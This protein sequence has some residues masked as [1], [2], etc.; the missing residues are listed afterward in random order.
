MVVWLQLFLRGLLYLAYAKQ[1]VN[2]EVMMV[3]EIENLDVED[4]GEEEVDSPKPKSDGIPPDKGLFTQDQLNKAVTSRVARQN[5][6]HKA[7]VDVLQAELTEAVELNEKYK[8]TLEKVLGEQLKKLQPEVKSLVDKLDP[9]S[10][11]EWLSENLARFVASS[12]KG[13]P[14]VPRSDG[15]GKTPEDLRRSKQ[16]RSDYKI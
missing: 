6:A 14:P 8:S 16:L 2:M 12:N 9:A 5:L 4:G 15:E 11:L 13:V 7:R 10:Q 1:A 3:D